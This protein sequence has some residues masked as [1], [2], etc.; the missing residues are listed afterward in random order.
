MRDLRKCEVIRVFG[1][2]LARE[3]ALS[4]SEP[5]VA[6]AP[7]D[8]A[9]GEGDARPSPLLQAVAVVVAAFICVVILIV[10]DR[11]VP[12][13]ALKAEV[14]LV[15]SAV[16]VVLAAISRTLRIAFTRLV[17]PLLRT[18]MIIEDGRIVGM[19]LWSIA[20]VVVLLVG[21]SRLV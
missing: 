1:P 21:L 16:P 19:R 17:Q 6:Q 7:K 18:M 12:P 3:T 9:S 5:S 10:A 2:M 14:V 11:F 8:A 4:E 20:V 15:V 13:S